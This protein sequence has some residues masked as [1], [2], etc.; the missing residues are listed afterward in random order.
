MS[1]HASEELDAYPKYK[2]NYLKAF[3]RMLEEREAAGLTN[4]DWSCAQ[5]VMDWWLGKRKKAKQIEGQKDLW[6]D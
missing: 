2:A 4:E 6:E 1:T 5:D 3:S